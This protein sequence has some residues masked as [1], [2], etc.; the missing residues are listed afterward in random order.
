MHFRAAFFWLCCSLFVL[1]GCSGRAPARESSQ[2]STTLYTAAQ[3]ADPGYIQYLERQSML[4]SQ[5]ELARVV[6]GSHLPWQRQAAAPEGEGL[7]RLADTWINI[8]PLTLLPDAK[9]STFNQFSNPSFWQ[10][11]GKSG[12]KGVYIAPTGGAG[13][14]WAY[15]RN[16]TMSGEDVIQYRFS[17]AAGDD[18]EYRRMLTS[19]NMGRGVLGTDLVPAAT[20][21]GPDF[22]L[23]TRNLR[24]FPG[25]YNMIEIPQALWPELPNPGSQWRG[26]ALGPE[27]IS[28]LASRKMLPPAMRRDSLP[29]GSR[30]GWA[31]TGEIHGVDGLIR[32]WVYRYDGAPDR[33]VL[34][35]EDPSAAAR[36]IFS[37]SA[38][39]QVGLLGNAFVGLRLSALYGMEA[40]PASGSSVPVYEPARDAAHSLGRE[41]RRYGGWSW[42]R[43]ETPLPL[44]R[45]VLAGG[46]DFALDSVTS[47]GVEH[48]M[49]TGDA[50][51]L[52]TMFDEALRQG[53]DMR[54]LV[55]AMPD[56]G[57]ISYA[58]PHLADLSVR[59]S[60]QAGSGLSPQAAGELR[61]RTLAAAQDLADK[62]QSDGPKGKNPSPMKGDTLYTTSAGAMAM[63]LGAGS[64]DSVTK[65]MGPQIMQGH[66]LLA[67]FKA[68]Q[69][70]VFLLS[71]QDLAG[72]LPL[73]WHSMADSPKDWDVSIGSRGAYAFTDT[74]SAVLVTNQGVAKAK[75]V[76]PPFDVQLQDPASF[77][78][79]LSR[80]LALR[81]RLGVAQGQLYGRF[82]THNPGTVAIVVLLPSADS[83]PAAGGDQKAQTA[84]E[85]GNS[86]FMTVSSFADFEENRGRLSAEQTR[87]RNDQARNVLGGRFVVGATPDGP[88]VGGNSALILVCNFSRKEATETLDLS[89]SP[90]LSRL[91]AMGG[92]ALVTENGTNQQGWKSSFTLTLQPWQGTAVLIGRDAK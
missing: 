7:L 89:V 2:S 85:T 51:L 14:L 82:L 67:F 13:A 83:A 32:R 59:S 55:H 84:P 41:V 48:A 1:S 8:H 11:M 49:L 71:G 77:A 44:L 42:L 47:P 43:D 68:L 81:A 70:G 53:L 74:S 78:S 35:W 63:A 19:A 72:T 39:Q 92:P 9:R 57:G 54:R 86:R 16:A 22:F 61:R 64:A 18:A 23:A 66:L 46:P 31:I 75:T 52:R 87:E 34:N 5:G 29:F 60:A 58:L 17:E 36:R 10:N 28:F 80:V 26:A 90:L 4:G 33:P 20:G 25:V 27:H 15:G 88:P 76:Y 40:A 6:S 79:R 30:G 45:E 73:S 38:I 3:R 65:E 37:G 21:L 69:P 56:P 62:T 24:D 12:I 91:A 50:T